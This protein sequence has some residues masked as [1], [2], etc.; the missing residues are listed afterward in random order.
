MRTETKPQA[1]E[2]PQRLPK[3]RRSRRWIVVT[4]AIVASALALYAYML[5][6]RPSP[7]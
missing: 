5:E 4:A 7:S 1:G 6:P 2:A 3:R